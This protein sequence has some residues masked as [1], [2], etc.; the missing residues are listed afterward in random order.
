MDR[1]RIDELLNL[2]REVD[3][4]ALQDYNRDLAALL[5]EHQVDHHNA[6]R[7]SAIIENLLAIADGAGLF[8]YE[9]TADHRLEDCLKFSQ[10]LDLAYATA[11]ST[12]HYHEAMVLFILRMMITQGS[13]PKLAQFCA[14]FFLLHSR[15][16]KS[17]SNGTSPGLNNGPPSDSYMPDVLISRPG[18]TGFDHFKDPRGALYP[19]NY[20]QDN[21]ARTAHPDCDPYLITGPLSIGS[22]VREAAVSRA[23]AVAERGILFLGGVGTVDQLNEAAGGAVFNHDSAERDV[24]ALE[25]LLTGIHAPPTAVRIWVGEFLA[26]WHNRAKGYSDVVFRTD[27]TGEDRVIVFAGSPNGLSHANSGWMLIHRA[28]LLGLWE[29]SGIR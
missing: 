8:S 25:S 28:R 29:I 20:A 16:H 15:P 6:W 3:W 11:L 22:E 5:D 12:G 17:A 26:F 1:V 24:R 7:L 10:R 19:D 21:Y 18:E 9:F 4:T 2:L 13:A 14:G 27:P 23:L